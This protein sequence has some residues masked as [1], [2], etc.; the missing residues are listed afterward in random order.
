[1]KRR[2]GGV[3][4]CLLVFVC[5]DSQI[6]AQKTAATEGHAEHRKV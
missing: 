6:M 3:L 2:L 4:L 1:M 5:G